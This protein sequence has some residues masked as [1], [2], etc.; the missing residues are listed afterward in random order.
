S[1]RADFIL[2]P[3]GAGAGISPAAA[4]QL[5]DLEELDAVVELKYSGA[6]V[7]G[8]RSAVVALDPNGLELVM[9]V[10]DPVG[11][12][13][14]SPAAVVMGTREAEAHGVE[15]GDTVVVTFPETGDVMLTLTA[16]VD[17]GPTTLISSPY[18]VSLPDFSANVT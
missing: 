2:K 16:T 7:H 15:V 6:Q 11:V 13:D 9:D 1:N 18:W 17:E 12:L 4:A 14:L 3:A 10:G 8:T 5:R